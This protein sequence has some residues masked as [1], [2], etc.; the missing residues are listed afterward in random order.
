MRHRLLW[1]FA[2]S[3]ALI[4]VILDGT[5]YK[6]NSGQRAVVTSFGRVIASRIG[7]GLHTKTPFADNVHIFNARLLGLQVEP[8]SLVTKGQKRLLVDAF[9]EWRI[10]SFRR[11]LTSAQGLRHIADE[12]LRQI[13]TSALRHTFGTRSLQQ[14][15]V[16]GE[17]AH[18]TQ[19][20]DK[21]AARYGLTVVDVRIQRI[22]LADH[23]SDS[24]EKR[25]EADQL[26]HAAKLEA[27]G[28][29]Q[30][31]TIHG[32]AN[33]KRAD[34][35]A[36]AYEKAE[37]IRSQGDSRAGAIYTHAYSQNPRFF[38][39][40]KSLRAYVHSFANR[41]TVLVVG[42]QSG[43]LRFLPNHAPYHK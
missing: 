25:M 8:R 43:F 31:E 20:V 5:F 11:Y 22:G 17:T 27:A 15:M 4:V 29:A 26:R 10:R 19:A 38:V 13:A 9:V 35:L 6:V 28:M 2:L 18:L 36:R 24:V 14:V 34:I 42:P 1:P 39:F 30:A 16:P 12:R 37:V 32:R 41:H 21:E 40:Y 3:V 33:Q 7:P 23:V